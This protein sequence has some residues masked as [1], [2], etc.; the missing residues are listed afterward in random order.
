MKKNIFL[1]FLTLCFCHVFSQ[2]PADILYQKGNNYFK[3]SKYEKAIE[4]YNLSIDIEPVADAYFNR[5]QCYFK[6]Q[7]S[8]NF[9]R[10]IFKASQLG[11]TEAEKIYN[12]RCAIFDTIREISDTIFE[13]F[14]GYSF[15]LKSRSICNED[16]NVRY[17]DKNGKNLINPAD[18][19][20]QKGNNYFKASKYEKAIEYYNLSID[21]EPVADAYFNRAQ[22]YF[23]LQ[24]SCNFCRDIFKASQLGDTEAE[25]IYNFRCAIFDTIREISDTI[26]EEFPGY[27]FTLKSR[28]ICNEDSNVRYCDKN[29]KNLISTFEKAPE[30]PGGDKARMIYLIENIKYPQE[31]RN[32]KKQGTVFITF[33]IE[34]DGSISNV[35]ILRSP[36]KLLSDEAIRIIKGMPKWKPGTRKGKPVRVQFNMP[37]KFTLYG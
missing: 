15:T 6:L 9:C 28:S 31:A 12:F 36:D 19:L 7:D 30:F 27:S 21:I 5:A 13:E 14:P 16:S 4:Y 3:A 35:K 8:C 26:F 1:L 24:D 32:S 23:K 33:F 11:D 25:K 18:I 29:G 2:N 37:I 22:C 10:D 20:Y 17:C 34:I